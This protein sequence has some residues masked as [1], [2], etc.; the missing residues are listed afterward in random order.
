MSSCRNVRAHVFSPLAPPRPAAGSVL[1]DEQ[2]LV[3]PLDLEAVVNAA[4]AGGFQQGYADGLRAVREEQE[5]AVHRLA[6][7]ARDALVESEQLTRALERQVV[8]LSLAIAEKVIERETRIDREIVLGVVRGALQELAGAIGV[9]VRVHPD[10]Y[11]LVAAHWQELE[12]GS[13]AQGGRLVAD[14]RVQPGGCLIETRAGQVDAQLSTRLD[15]VAQT[16]RAVL[17]GEPA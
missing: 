7:L 15:Q 12:H 17:D 10:E 4:A 3:A 9:Q 1:V 14:D 16:L 5:P 2:P 6:A 13:A 11:D 8:E